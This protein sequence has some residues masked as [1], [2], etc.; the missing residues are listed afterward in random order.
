MGTS[1]P[2]GPRETPTRIHARGVAARYSISARLA[3][4]WIAR[5]VRDGVAVKVG[6]WTMARPSEL[7]AWVM[8]GAGCNRLARRTT[9]GPL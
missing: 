1:P 6:R 9:G 7:D 5:A 2:A 8:D 4:D 3:E